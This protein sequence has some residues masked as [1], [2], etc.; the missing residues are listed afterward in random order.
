MQIFIAAEDSAAVT[1]RARRMNTLKKEKL[2]TNEKS[3]ELT[4]MKFDREGYV[5]KIVLSQRDR[6]NGEL[7]KDITAALIKHSEGYNN[8]PV[9]YFES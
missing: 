3:K 1:I 2:R 8:V 9:E 5:K 7:M 4:Y 6:S